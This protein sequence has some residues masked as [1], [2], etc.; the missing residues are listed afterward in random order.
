MP[1][2][3]LESTLASF[4]CQTRITKFQ[5]F[6]SQEAVSWRSYPVQHGRLNTEMENASTEYRGAPASGLR[7]PRPTEPDI[8]T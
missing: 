7:P 3:F 8:E 5:D 2:P 6:S 1:Y 4:K